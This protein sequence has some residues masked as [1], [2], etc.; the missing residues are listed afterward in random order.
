LKECYQLKLNTPT[1]ILLDWYKTSKLNS[2]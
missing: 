2:R 1:R